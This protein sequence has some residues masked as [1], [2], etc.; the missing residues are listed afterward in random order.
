MFVITGTFES[1]RFIPDQPVSIPEKKRVKII[2]EEQTTSAE[3]LPKITMAQIEEWSKTPEIQSLVGALKNA[4]LP[5]D[6]TINDIRNERLKEKY[7]A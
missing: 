2:I 6:I 1:G 7:G 3:K 5:L 4:S